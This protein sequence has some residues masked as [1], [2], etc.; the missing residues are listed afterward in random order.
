MYLIYRI[1]KLHLDSEDELPWAAR[2]SINTKILQGCVWS[3]TEHLSQYCS[4]L[5]FHW[6]WLSGPHIWAENH[7]PHYVIS[8]I[9]VLSTFPRKA[10][11]SLAERSW[12]ILLFNL[13]SKHIE[14]LPCSKHYPEDNRDKRNHRPCLQGAHG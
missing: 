3:F 5:C 6:R 2:S 8:I 14:C 1:Y 13:F 9:Y 11:N 12:P 4:L 10:M 7:L